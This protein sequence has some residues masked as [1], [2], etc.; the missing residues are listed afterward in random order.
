[1]QE[2]DMDWNLV[3]EQPAND[4][5]PLSLGNFSQQVIIG[6]LNNRLN[7]LSSKMDFIIEKLDKL[8]SKIDDIET[9]PEKRSQYDEVIFNN[10]DID[11]ILKFDSNEIEN[12][13]SSNIPIPVQMDEETKSERNLLNNI[14][15][16][17][18]K[19]NNALNNKYFFQNNIRTDILSRRNSNFSFN[20]PF[21]SSY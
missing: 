21:S 16:L 19:N 13:K 17:Y 4:N 12:F 5:E 18:F 8:E 20:L 15:P 2:G 10:P 3:D 11:K 7:E 9:D 6:T 14:N 1:M